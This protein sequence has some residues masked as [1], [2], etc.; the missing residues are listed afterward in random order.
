MFHVLSRLTEHLITDNQV[1]QES[2]LKEARGI[3]YSEEE[4]SALQNP[5][6]GVPYERIFAILFPMGKFSGAGVIPG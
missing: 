2:C 1:F 4:N 3:E 6:P 5:W